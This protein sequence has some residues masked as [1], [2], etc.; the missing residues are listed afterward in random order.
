MY[1]TYVY[2]KQLDGIGRYGEVELGIDYA[3]LGNKVVDECNWSKLNEIYP[4]F[5]V[6][7]MLEIWKE[8]AISAAQSIQ[9]NYVKNHPSKVIIRD[10]VGLAV[11]TKPSHIGA[12]TIIGIFD[13]WDS[14]L[15]DEDLIVL[16]EF[17]KANNEKDLIPDYDKLI[18]GKKRKN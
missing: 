18:I 7:A 11:D 2:R 12:A 5:I 1:K 14:P 9:T 4:N 8:S 10:I 6:T 13:M 15:S 3:S 16:D 17:V